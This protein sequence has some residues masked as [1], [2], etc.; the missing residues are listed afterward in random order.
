MTYNL[1]KHLFTID[2]PM[3]AA[4]VLLLSVGL[5]G[6]MGSCEAIDN[7]DSH[8]VCQDYCTKKFD[9]ESRKPTS[10]ET[11]T[12]VSACRNSIEDDC[13][14]EHQGAAN[15]KIGECVDNSCVEFATCMVFT[16]APE[17][18]GFVGQ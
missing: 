3:L 11:E 9:C 4:S 13:G 6:L 2:S 16:A 15:D 10:D 14:N 7:F 12:C 8:V 17:C 1:A 5:T 18:F